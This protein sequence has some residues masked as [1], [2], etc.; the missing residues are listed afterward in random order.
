MM[1]GNSGLTAEVWARIYYQSDKD[2]EN[3]YDTKFPMITYAH[4]ATK[5]WE[6]T[7]RS[8]MYQITS[9]SDSYEEARRVAEIVFWIFRKYR[10]TNWA[11]NF[12]DVNMIN[13]IYDEEF[14]THGVA[15]TL[16][17]IERK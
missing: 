7:K 5:I 11:F 10:P 12:A 2:A 4:L 17:V 9:W 16:V 6:A 15:L 1:T 3:N 14:E 13:S 8:S